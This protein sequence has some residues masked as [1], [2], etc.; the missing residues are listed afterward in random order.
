MNLKL[1]KIAEWLKL[2]PCHHDVMCTGVSIDTRTLKKGEL[3]IA[4]QGEQFNGHDF[5]S[6]AIEQGAVA[7]IADHPVHVDKTVPVF[8][9]DDT[10]Q[11]LGQ[12][13]TLYRAEFTLP[14]VAITGSCGKTT[15]KT[16]LASIFEQR[17]NVLAT[18]GTLNNDIGVPL[19]L[20]R[21]RADHQFAVIE[22]G[23]NH[24][25][26]IANIAQM[27]QA[28]V[29]VI[30][31]AAPVHLEGFGDVA[32]V[33][34][35]K[36]EIID[37]V[38]SSGTVI[39]NVGDA[40]YPDWRERA[41][42]RNV[43]TFG[44]HASADVSAHNI[45][46]NPASQAC[47]QLHTRQGQCSIQLSLLGQHHVMNA[48]AAAAAAEVFNFSLE[49][50]AAG[51]SL[52]KPVAKRLIRQ[53][54]WQGA[55]IIDDTYNANPSSFRAAI[56]FLVQLPGEKIL[57]VGD[58][59]ELGEQAEYFHRELGTQARALGVQQLCAVGVWSR[60]TALAFGPQ[61]TH[62]ETKAELISDLRQR[63][64]AG[65]TVLVKGSRS[66]KM[67]DVVVALL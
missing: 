44:L 37:K 24:A 33:A 61:A 46:L 27:A 5:I 1:S 10:R 42:A 64:S 14:V 50:I 25:G 66:A 16:L 63:L 4:I 23:A 19:T 38:A 17:A 12:L 9:V 2:K 30:T 21:L 18:Q 55:S 45:T 22:L 11:A 26:E 3:F 6:Q 43:I 41:G 48:L 52:A 15:T 47:F 20:F 32:G 59:A 13:A 36:G 67:E 34:R 28:D 29:V 8:Y 7:V 56:E 51:L 31:N 65:M 60:F 39:L 58:M 62:F 57:I 49:E 54:G 53:S 35:A 40:Y